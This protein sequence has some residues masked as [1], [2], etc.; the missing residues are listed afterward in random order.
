MGKI[1]REFLTLRGNGKMVLSRKVFYK[2]GN[3]MIITLN[4]Y[5]IHKFYHM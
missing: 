4:M 3:G 1:T 2:G 5:N